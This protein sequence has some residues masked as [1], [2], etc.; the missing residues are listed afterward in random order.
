[1]NSNLNVKFED[2]WEIVRMLIRL[3]FMLFFAACN[4][5]MS[6]KKSREA[7]SLKHL[8]V[9]ISVLNFTEKRYAN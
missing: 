2:D 9:S 4:E 3:E 7:A 6:K 8:K 1:M 5:M